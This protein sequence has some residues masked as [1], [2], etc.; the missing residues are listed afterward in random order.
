MRQITNHTQQVTGSAG[1]TATGRVTAVTCTI[2]HRTQ[3]TKAAWFGDK[4]VSYS[5]KQVTGA[6]WELAKRGAEVEHTEKWCV[7]IGR[8]SNGV[9]G[10]Q[11]YCMGP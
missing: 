3:L 10:P 1:H 2:A 8:V 9:G 5:Q 7:R 11:Q 6:M 4:M